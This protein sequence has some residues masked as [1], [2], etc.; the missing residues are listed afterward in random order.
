M[1][2]DMDTFV[3]VYEQNEGKQITMLKEKIKRVLC[4]CEREKERALHM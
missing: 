2:I 4:V 3:Y 1:E